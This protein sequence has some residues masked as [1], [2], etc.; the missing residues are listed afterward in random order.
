MYSYL[1]YGSFSSRLIVTAWPCVL[2]SALPD[3]SDHMPRMLLPRRLPVNCAPVHTRLSHLTTS[4][5]AIQQNVE[6]NQMSLNACVL[7]DDLSLMTVLIVTHYSSSGPSASQSTGRVLVNPFFYVVILVKNN[8]GTA[9][10]SPNHTEDYPLDWSNT[11][12]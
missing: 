10:K 8:S 1:I 4:G 9:V 5:M 12:R 2:R 7:L 11:L 3:R 6:F